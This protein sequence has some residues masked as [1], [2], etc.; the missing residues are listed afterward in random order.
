MIRWCLLSAMLVSL[1]PPAL[2]AGDW[3]DSSPADFAAGSFLDA[4]SNLYVSAKGRMQIVNRWDLNGDGHLD[5][6]IPSGHCHTEKEDTFIYLNSGDDIQGRSLIRL[7]ANGSRD[8]VIFDFNKD[9]FND[10]AVCNGDNGITTRTNS[11]VYYGDAKGLSVD[12]RLT[13]PSYDSTS[14]AIGDFD[15]DGWTDLTIACQW[16]DGEY[17]HPVGPKMSFVYWN[18]PNGFKPDNRTSISIKEQGFSAVAAGDLDGDSKSDLVFAADGQTYI[19]YSKDGAIKDAAKR[20][21]IP[22]RASAAAVGDLDHDGHPD[23]V[24]ASGDSVI[25]LP[26]RE[27]QLDVDRRIT[28]EGRQPS[29]FAIDDF[30]GDGRNDLAVANYAGASGE[31]WVPSYVYFAGEEGLGKARRLELPTMGAHSVSTGDLNDDGRPELVFSNERVTNQNSIP[32]LVYWNRDGSFRKGAHTE[33]DTQGAVGSA[34]GD[35]NNDDKPDVVFFNFE[36]N[37]RDGASYTRIYWG[38]GTRNYSPLRSLDIPT[39]YITSVGHADLD[40]DGYVDLVLTQSRF[41]NGA[42]EKMFNSVIICWGD[43]EATFERRTR[44]TVDYLAGGLR[45]ADLNRDGHVDLTIG[46]FCFDEK[47]PT[48]KTKG[49]PVFWGSAN[50]YSQTNRTLFTPV[51]EYPRVPLIADVN[52]DGIPDMVAQVEFGT[53][54]LWYGTEKGIPQ[55]SSE[56]LD[57]GREDNLVFL[58]AADLNKDGWLDLILPTRQLGK[59]AEASSFIYYGSA[60]GF[61]NERREEVSSNGLYEV[62]VADFDKDG[63]LDLFFTSYKGN[64]RRNLP[65]MIHWGTPSGFGSRPPTDIPTLAASGIETADYDGDGWI[66]LLISNHRK[67][68]FTDRPGPHNHLTTSMLYWGDREGFSPARRWDFVANGPHAMNIRDVGNGVDRRLAEE[69]VSRPYQVAEGERPVKLK[70]TA[71]TPLNTR[72]ELRL[73]AAGTR[74]ALEKA[75]WQGPAGTESWYAQSDS[76]ITGLSGRWVQYQARLSTPNG[77]ATPYLTSVTVQFAPQAQGDSE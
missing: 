10:L 35:V 46:A 42:G 31:T 2:R 37:F 23:L 3:T 30:D 7:A 48:K 19:C 21:T 52:R 20:V 16:Q 58:D 12:R 15:G 68:G 72:V 39:H 24:L 9:G 77:G 40:D 32:S 36:G 44:L 76:S 75:A 8:G 67:D 63:W 65:S 55:Q 17:V 45:I 29:D 13:L 14:L 4:G 41:V 56:R 28:L 62:S 70:W 25:I 34:I 66:D 60:N 53:I 57:L 49:L 74:E 5:L 22:L 59:D 6:I 47:D 43:A 69:Y 54:D 71:Q 18:G 73:R 26:A 27:G 64:E 11:Y 1:N 33:L 51:A 38:D 61:S 50:G